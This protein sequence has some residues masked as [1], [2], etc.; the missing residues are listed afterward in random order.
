VVVISAKSVE[1]SSEGSTI[2]PN[3]VI[4]IEGKSG[5]QIDQYLEFLEIPFILRYKVLNKRLDV[6]VLGGVSTNILV[7]NSVYLI[8]GNEKS[9]IG[10][11]EGLRSLNYSGNIGFGIDYDLGGNFMITFEPQLKYYMNSINTT[12]YISN[13]PYSFGMFTGIRYIF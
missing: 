9:E 3:D 5:E 12:D 1:T 7:G 4:T 2:T 8:S 13:R 6:N 10:Q 11:T